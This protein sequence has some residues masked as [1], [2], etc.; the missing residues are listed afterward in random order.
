MF[1]VVERRIWQ[2]VIFIAILLGVAVGIMV[3]FDD[4]M[5]PVISNQLR[6]V[7]QLLGTG[8]RTMSGTH[9][10]GGGGHGGMEDDSPPNGL[11]VEDQPVFAPAAIEHDAAPTDGL[12]VADH[13]S[14]DGRLAVYRLE[15]D[16]NNSR[17]LEQLNEL[18][19]TWGAKS[20]PVV[21]AEI[22]R[23]I[24]RAERQMQTEGLLRVQGVEDAVVVLSESEAIVVVASELSVAEVE[25]I[26]DVVARVAGIPLAHI[27]IS[28]GLSF[29]Q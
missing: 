21:Q 7:G 2:R 27:T 3:T 22:V 19:T 10:V 1:H 9:V 15:R 18:I 8:D 13:D 23:L 20:D 12:H 6:L 29:P 28:D 11:V 5:E 24:G 14:N 25:H 16:R 17:Y 4:Q 26:G